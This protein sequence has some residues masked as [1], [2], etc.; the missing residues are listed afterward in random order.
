M[1]ADHTV[2]ATFVPKAA[3][4]LTV[5][6][7]T[8]PLYFTMGANSVSYGN[9]G[10]CGGSSGNGT[11]HTCQLLGL[12]AGKTLVFTVDPSSPNHVDN[13]SG[14]TPSADLHSCTLTPNQGPNAVQVWFKY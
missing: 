6:N 10:T 8:A 1:S 3:V 2:T 5:Q 4:T 11:T 9:G 14:C 12:D 7:E 13:W